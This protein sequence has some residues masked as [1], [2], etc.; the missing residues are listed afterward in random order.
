[1]TYFAEQSKK[2]KEFDYQLQRS[3]PADFPQEGLVRAAIG[4][5]D[6]AIG[7]GNGDESEEAVEED[8]KAKQKAQET[9]EGSIEHDVE[10][11]AGVERIRCGDAV[12]G[13]GEL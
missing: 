12:D 10:G 8:A 4:Q 2:A 1:M 6:G 9:S 11:G 5:Q 3:V 13:G 7:V